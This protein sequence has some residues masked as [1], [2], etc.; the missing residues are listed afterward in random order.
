M[1]WVANE[2]LLDKKYFYLECMRIP[3]D[4]HLWV[5]ILGTEKEAEEFQV[6]TLISFTRFLIINASYDLCFSIYKYFVSQVTI[7]LFREDEYGQIGE[8]GFSAQRSYTGPVS[9]I[10]TLSLYIVWSSFIIAIKINVA[11]IN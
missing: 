11:S 5:Y 3:P 10:F 7:T 9:N 8:N 2:L 6:E 4:W 1:T